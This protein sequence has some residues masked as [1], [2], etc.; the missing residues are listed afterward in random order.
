MKNYKIFIG[1]DCGVNTG[2][3]IWNKPSRIIHDLQ[4]YKIHQAMDHVRKYADFMQGEVFVR[5]EDARKRKWIPWS[6][7]EK[8]E[9]GRR[10]GA[11]SVKRDAIIWE[12]FLTD[13]KIPFELVAPKNNKTKVTS[14]YF[15]RISGYTAPTNQHERDAAMLVLAF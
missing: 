11:G 5:I 8:A 1:I 9:R 2:L 12:D 13:L 3:C 4:V 7:N 14:D 10:E 15:K 6:K